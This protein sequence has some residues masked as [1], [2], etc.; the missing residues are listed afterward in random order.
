MRIRIT[1]GLLTAH[2]IALQATSALAGGF[3]S[4]APKIVKSVEEWRKVLDPQQFHVCREKGTERAFTGR[5]WNNHRAGTYACVACGQELFLSTTKF[6]S[7][8]G[9]PSFYAAVN[10]TAVETHADHS[11]G[12]ERVEIMCSHCGSHLG[13]VFKDGP[14]PTGLRYC[15]NSAS[16][17]FTPAPAGQK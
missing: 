13:H 12:M 16:L 11:L 1:L 7:G 8:T 15:T 5:Y 9:W 3:A 17:K 6:D 14:K 10:T 2:W 4:P